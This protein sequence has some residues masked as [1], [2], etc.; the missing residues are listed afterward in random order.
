VGRLVAEFEIA[1]ERLARLRQRA[2]V[3]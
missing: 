3:D 2:E 1:V